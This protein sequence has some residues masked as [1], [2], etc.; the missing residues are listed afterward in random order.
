MSGC[1]PQ[2]HVIDMSDEDNVCR[3]YTPELQRVTG[4]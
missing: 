3:S 1:Y 2:I 4:R